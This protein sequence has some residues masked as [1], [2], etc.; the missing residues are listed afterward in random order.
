MKTRALECGLGGGSQEAEGV[1]N[2][3]QS[4]FELSPVASRAG[5]GKHEHNF[6]LLI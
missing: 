5:G 4:L 2:K 3:S 1:A 6:L